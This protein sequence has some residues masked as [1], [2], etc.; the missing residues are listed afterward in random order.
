[1]ALTNRYVSALAAGGGDGSSGSPWTLT[2]A[3]DLATAGDVVNVK[4]DGTYAVGATILAPTPPSAGTYQLPIVYRGYKTTIGDGYQGRLLGGKGVLDDTNMP[5]ITFTTGKFNLTAV[6]FHLFETL[7]LQATGGG[8][9]DPVVLDCASSVAVKSCIITNASTQSSSGCFKESSTNALLIDCDM[10]SAAGGGFTVAGDGTRLVVLG[11]RYKNSSATAGSAAIRML[12]NR[13][14]FSGA[15]IYGSLNGIL[16]STGAAAWEMIVDGCTIQGCTNGISLPSGV[17]GYFAVVRNCMI[18]D[19]V[20]AGIVAAVDSML[21]EVGNYYRNNG[22]D[23]SGVTD[24]NTAAR[25]HSVAGSGSSSVDFR[26]ASNGDFRLHNISAA[27]KASPGYQDAGALVYQS[28]KL[29]ELAGP[30]DTANV[31][32]DDLLMMVGM[33]LVNRRDAAA[34][35]GN[36]KVYNSAGSVIGTRTHTDDGTTGSLTKLV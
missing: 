23:R 35:S 12:A 1:M 17:V 28:Q 13:S 27:R 18:T 4:A 31:D 34:G 30:I 33:L 6:T 36:V 24:W 32:S 16:G 2:E 15:I 5:L 25:W 20:T 22:A 3:F 26:D 29:T 14:I 7:K 10:T 19:N 8:G 11:G 21:V 9:S